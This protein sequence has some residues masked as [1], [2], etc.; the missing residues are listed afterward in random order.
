MLSFVPTAQL[1]IEKLSQGQ[2]SLQDFCTTSN[3]FPTSRIEFL[4]DIQERMAG[5]VCG[6]VACVVLF[7]SESYRRLMCCRILPEE[8]VRGIGVRAKTLLE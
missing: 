6:L 3:A 1:H 8:S 4:T 5:F 7:T 2:C